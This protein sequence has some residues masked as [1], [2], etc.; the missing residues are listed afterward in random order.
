MP[1]ERHRLI[2][3][4]IDAVGID[5]GRSAPGGAYASVVE[6][7]GILYVSGMVPALDGQVAVAGKVGAEVSLVEAQRAARIS[8]L[9]CLAAVGDHLGDLGRLRKVLRVTVYIQGAP[10]FYQLSEVANGA[11]ELLN[12]VLAP[13]GAHSRTSV[14]VAT[15]PRNAA[16]EVDMMVSIQPA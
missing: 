4:R 6:E 14:G 16:L 2:Q 15:L 12:A 8:T 10:G 5:L 11:S 7:S 13:D 1:S 9:R 3:S